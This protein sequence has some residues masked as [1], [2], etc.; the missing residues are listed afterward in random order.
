MTLDSQLST[1]F[2]DVNLDAGERPEALADGSEAALLALVSSVNVACG[3]HAG[4]EGTMAATLAAARHL[5]VAC[6]AHPGYPDRAGFGRSTVAMTPDEIAACVAGQIGALDRVAA[7]LGIRLAHVKPHGALYNDT[8]RD[9]AIA[10]AVARGA[11]P[12][13]GRVRL[14]GLAESPCLE[15]YRAAGFEALAEA[16]A[17]RRYEPDGTL[18]A[19]R[20][21]DAVIHDP[22]EAAAQ[23]VRV[24]CR[25]EV[26][27]VDGS[28]LRLR[29]ETVCIHSDSPAA[30]AVARAVRQ[31][32]QA[33]GVTVTAPVWP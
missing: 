31:A 16:F 11:A 10:A 4:D 13:R 30:L 9:P 18:R 17:E 21:P 27:A 25:G 1:R 2:I 14:V 8:A 24:A 19:R 33:A 12:W 23:A 29:A 28:M 7:G 32:L 5:G 22:E 20:F 3:G 26:V 6:G 15:V